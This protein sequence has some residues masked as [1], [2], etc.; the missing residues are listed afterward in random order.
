MVLPKKSNPNI[1]ASVLS[2]WAFSGAGI[3]LTCHGINVVQV[4]RDQR[5]LQ[6]HT[7]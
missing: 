3:T 1:S 5:S 6:W 2:E 4:L 7:G